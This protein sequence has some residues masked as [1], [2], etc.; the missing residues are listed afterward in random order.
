MTMRILLVEDEKYL[1]DAIAHILKREGFAVDVV[2]DGQSGLDYALKDIY[3]A[4]VLDNMLPMLA[5]TE[6]LRIL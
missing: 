1:A 6:V 3:D 2:H 5:G 4:V